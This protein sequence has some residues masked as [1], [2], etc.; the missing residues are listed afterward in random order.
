MIKSIVLV[1]LV[2]GIG[3]GI[4]SGYLGINPQVN[5]LQESIQYKNQE[6]IEKLS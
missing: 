2:I 5:E 3:I 1:Y 4:G 6:I